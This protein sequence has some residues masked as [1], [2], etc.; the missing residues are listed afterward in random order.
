MFTLTKVAW[1]RRQ[2]KRTRI[3]HPGQS[4]RDRNVPIS[5]SMPKV[6]KA[7]T[8][9]AV[10]CRCRRHYCLKYNANVNYPLSNKKICPCHK[11]S[12]G[13][14]SFRF[15]HN[16]F[17]DPN[18]FKTILINDFKAALAGNCHQGDQIGQFLPIRLLLEV[19]CEF[20]KSQRNRDILGCFWLKGIDYMFT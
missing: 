2:H 3:G 20:L 13:Q 17:I 6:S 16:I 9:V 11:F 5:V 4:N 18:L 12:Q 8:I 1:Q 7:S 15:N 10:A 14:I 19:H